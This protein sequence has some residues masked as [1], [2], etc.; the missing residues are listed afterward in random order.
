MIPKKIHYCWFGGNEMSH[1]S[2]RCMS[3]WEAFLPDYELTLWNESN[4]PIE[5]PIVRHAIKNKMWAFA[6]DYTRLHALQKYGGIYLDTD[7]E[8]I[9]N[10]DHLLKGSEVLLGEE[11]DGMISAGIICATPNSNFISECIREMRRQFSMGKRFV[12]IPKIITKT[13]LDYAHKDRCK[14]YPPDYFYPY[15]PYDTNQPVKQLMHRDI[16]PN[17]CTI[18]HWENSWKQNFAK[19]A[20]NKARNSAIEW[21][22]KK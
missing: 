22:N 12:T 10:L 5:E 20:L 15:N 4:A 19:R 11:S 14:I 16:T 1:L 21:I 8:I 7:M 13:Y 2:K 3:S 6:A 9:K 18:H 17:T